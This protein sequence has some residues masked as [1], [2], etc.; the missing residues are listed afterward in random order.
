MIWLPLR[1]LKNIHDVCV[2]CFGNILSGEFIFYIKTQG[3]G[4][5]TSTKGNVFP[6]ILSQDM[7]FSETRVLYNLMPKLEICIYWEMNSSF[8]LVNLFSQ[9]LEKEYCH[10]KKG[11]EKPKIRPALHA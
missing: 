11:G 7:G 2:L 9:F 10:M 8:I 5:Y 4:S 3:L 6:Q 1:D